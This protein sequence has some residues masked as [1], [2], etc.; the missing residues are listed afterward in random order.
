[1][2]TEHEAAVIEQERR[3]IVPLLPYWFQQSDGTI[4]VEEACSRSGSDTSLRLYVLATY[5]RL[6][7]NEPMARRPRL[8]CRIEIIQI[9]PAFDGANIGPVGCFA[10][11][12]EQGVRF[13]ALGAARHLGLGQTLGLDPSWS[14][15]SDGLNI[16]S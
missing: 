11:T 4:E 16:E 1:M 13:L 5:R 8:G 15:G 10:W 6:D 12:L 7:L 3:R 9:R 14:R 2:W